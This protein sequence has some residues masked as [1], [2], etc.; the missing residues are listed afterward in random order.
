MS[1]S[2][3]GFWKTYFWNSKKSEIKYAHT[4]K[5]SERTVEISEKNIVYFKLYKKKFWQNLSLYVATN[6]FFL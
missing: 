5:H 1:T 3:L 6:L 4:S 2:A